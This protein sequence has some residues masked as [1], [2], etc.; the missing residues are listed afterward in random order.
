MNK[1]VNKQSFIIQESFVIY[2]PV[3]SEI[4]KIA[5]QYGSP[6][7]WY[8]HDVDDASGVL[9]ARHFRAVG[10]CSAFEVESGC[11]HIETIIDA[12]SGFVWHIFEVTA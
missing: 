8:L 3:Y 4:I 11:Q 1:I 5:Y 2:M 6:T 7:I 12:V 10:T 9:V